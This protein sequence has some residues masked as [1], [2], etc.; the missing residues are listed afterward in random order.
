[1][2]KLVDASTTVDVPPPPAPPPPPPRRSI[3]RGDPVTLAGV[4][5][6]VFDLQ[7]TEDGDPA[8][9]SP[10]SVTAAALEASAEP[11][12]VVDTKLYGPDDRGVVAPSSIYPHL[13]TALPTGV[14]VDQLTRIE[15][16]VAP[17]GIVESVKLV[18]G[19]APVMVTEAMLLSAAK[20]W[21]FSPA[22]KEGEPVRYRKT[23]F[24]SEK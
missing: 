24:L 13:P 12:R 11:N 14:S 10:A 23:V 2:G 9:L 20:A 3:S 22:M 21:R 19:R 15:L 16:I 18:P 5:V 17:D 7:P 6:K 8:V 4:P 1:M